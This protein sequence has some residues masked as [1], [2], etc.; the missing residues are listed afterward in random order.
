MRDAIGTITIKG[1]SI[2]SCAH[3]SHVGRENVVS[4][5]KT[6]CGSIE[7]AANFPHEIVQLDLQCSKV[8]LAIHDQVFNALTLF[9]EPISKRLNY[10]REMI[11]GSEGKKIGVI[12]HAGNESVE[13]ILVMCS[14]LKKFSDSDKNKAHEDYP[15]KEFF[16]ASPNA[17]QLHYG[18]APH[19]AELSQVM[20]RVLPA[21]NSY[22][23]A[24]E[25]LVALVMGTIFEHHAKVDSSFNLEKLEFNGWAIE[26]PHHRGES[27]LLLVDSPSEDGVS[28]PQEGELCMITLY[29][30]S[31]VLPAKTQALKHITEELYAISL[32]AKHKR[33]PDK[34]IIERCKGRINP[35]YLTSDNIDHLRLKSRETPHELQLRLTGLVNSWAENDSF[36]AAIHEEPSPEAADVGTWKA[37]RVSLPVAGTPDG[38]TAYF[39]TIPLVPKDEALPDE[40]RPIIDVNFPILKWKDSDLS[41]NDRDFFK[42]RVEDHFKNPEMNLKVKLKALISDKAE[43]AMISAINDLHTPQSASKEFPVSDWSLATYRYL[44]D[45]NSGILYETKKAAYAALD[46]L[47]QNIKWIIGVAG[48]GKTKFLQFII[49][50]AIFGDKEKTH[51]TKTIYF[52]N[53]NTGVNDFSSDLFHFEE[54]NANNAVIRLHNFETEVED[55]MQDRV[56][57]NRREIPF[58]SDDAKRA[59]A[60]I[61]DHFLAQHQLAQLALDMNNIRSQKKKKK[62]KSLSLNEAAYRYFQERPSEYPDLKD[63]LE[64]YD[65]EKSTDIKESVT[66]LY[67]DF[68]EQFTGV[69]TPTPHAGC[70]SKFVRHF[71]ANICLLDEAAKVGD[72]TLL[73]I[74]RKHE[75]NFL[76]AQEQ[77]K[78]STLERAANIGGIVTSSLTVNHRGRGGLV[79]L[80]SK[81]IY[82][83]YMQPAVKGKDAWP[84]ETVAWH[85][86]LVAKCPR[87]SDDTQR[88][89]VELQGATTKKLGTS[90]FNTEHVAYAC[91]VAIEA[92][93][94]HNLRGLNGKAKDVLIISFY[95][96]QVFQY[97]RE[98]DRRM[99]KGELKQDERQQIILRT[100]DSSQGFSADFVIVD[101]VQAFCPGFTCDRQRVCVALTRDRQA[102]VI[103]MPRGIF[104]GFRGNLMEMPKGYDP[105]LL[106]MIYEDIGNEGGIITQVI[107]TESDTQDDTGVSDKCYNCGQSGHLQKQCCQE[108]KC[109][110]CGDSFHTTNTVSSSLP[111]LY[112]IFFLII[113]VDNA[114]PIPLYL[115]AC[116][117]IWKEARKSWAMSREYLRRLSQR[118]T[119]P[120]SQDENDDD[121]A[122]PIEHRKSNEDDSDSDDSDDSDDWD[123]FQW[124]D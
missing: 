75:P 31:R 34:L 39:V 78:I 97:Q 44:L 96:A 7:Q 87:L 77:L 30:I 74:I 86:F 68:L 94:D 70:L 15:F 102:E 51:L 69:V 116:I 54:L 11:S 28:Q 26:L 108:M 100:V 33:D 5:L 13:Y 57:K 8:N 85:S 83:H 72:L 120:P 121:P 71:K 41:G 81:I 90:S 14:M 46:N 107:E 92:V 84:T 122:Q 105:R 25:Q 24:E 79:A 19:P 2:T 82:H 4:A 60:G 114:G 38:L 18:N 106:E 56:T 6:F 58:D 49:L 36:F 111:R 118:F 23:N 91:D 3:H 103:L 42:T 62:L 104:V 63:A 61:D 59:C 123:D 98:L 9:A 40:Q 53:Q 16:K 73:Q 64:K 22:D 89:L 21:V 43:R 99:R 55:W 115:G 48:T 12:F 109:Q 27:F 1:A 76:L 35:D 93:R 29:N 65:P 124:M 47:V 117:P 10:I 20:D 66:K 88:I 32:E 112:P 80:P 110:N 113:E 52:V 45:R 101:F 37:E 67:R 17:Q 119:K 50:M 95:T